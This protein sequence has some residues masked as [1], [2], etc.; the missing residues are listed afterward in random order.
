MA[1]QKRILVTGGTGLVGSAIKHVVEN[2]NDQKRDD[3]QF[4]FISSKDCDLKSLVSFVNNRTMFDLDFLFA[5]LETE[6]KP[7]CYLKNINRPMLFI[8]LR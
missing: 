5:H 1:E 8:W 4:F 7:N 3:E 2:E 6:N